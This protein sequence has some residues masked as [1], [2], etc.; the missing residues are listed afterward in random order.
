MERR[1]KKLE[2]GGDGQEKVLKLKTTQV[3][4]NITALSKRKK[5]KRIKCLT[6]HGTCH[7]SLLHATGPGYL[8]TDS[9]SFLQKGEAHQGTRP[10]WAS[11]LYVVKSLPQSCWSTMQ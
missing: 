8:V 1:V 6:K 5:R 9:R 2:E 10:T 3:S 11:V 7:L 4:R